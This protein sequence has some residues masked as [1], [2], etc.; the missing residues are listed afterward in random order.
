MFVGSKKKRVFIPEVGEKVMVYDYGNAEKRILLVHGWSGRGT[1]MNKIAK[2]LLKHGYMTV[3]FDAPAHG[4]S[5]GRMTHMG[6]FIE[7][8]KHLDKKYGGF[9]II[10]GHSLGGAATLNA[11]KEG[12]E[13]HKAV[14]ISAVDIITD[15][16]NHFTNQL[17]LNSKVAKNLKASLDKKFEMDID[18]NS[19]SL[20]VKEID[21]PILVIHDKDDRDVPV[22][23]AVN[24]HKHLKKGQL[25]ITE[26]LG[27][28]RIL[29]NDEVTQ[30][31]VSFITS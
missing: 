15:V 2:E 23:C 26:E 19:P 21:V 11:L 3:S 27:H 5:T 29:R 7:V 12:V 16:V 28:R 13:V 25:I 31:I 14:T 20:V 1:Q 17:Q 22:E 9:D 4:K 6:E 30:K 8:I 24:I 10:I 18:E